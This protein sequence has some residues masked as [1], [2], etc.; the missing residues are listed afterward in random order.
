MPTIPAVCPQCESQYQVDAALVGKRMRCPNTICR[1]VFEVKDPNAKPA[2]PPAPPVI[3]PPVVAPAAPAPPPKQ[4]S[5][6]VA[7]LVPVLTAEAAETPPAPIP[8]PA[9]ATPAPIA[10]PPKRKKEKPETPAVRETAPAPVEAPVAPNWQAAPPP[11]R[12]QASTDGPP[13][14]TPGPQASA[15]A[16]AEQDLD[17]SELEGDAGEAVAEPGAAPT[18]VATETVV[19]PEEEPHHG[20]RRSLGLIVVMMLVLAGLGLGAFYLIKGKQAGNEAEHYDKAVEAYKKQDYAKAVTLLQGLTRDF[21][22]SGKRAEYRFLTE[23]SDLRLAVHKPSTDPAEVSR[24]LDRV[25]EFTELYKNDP[26][27]KDRHA[28]VWQSLEHVAKDLAVLAA[29]KNSGELLGR[30]KVAWKAAGK[31]TPPAGVSLPQEQK[32]FNE[33]YARIEKGIA[34][35]TYR[36]ES[37]ALLRKTAAGKGT[38]RAVEAAWRTIEDR[39]LQG[40]EEAKKLLGEL[41]AAHRENVAYN[42]VEKLRPLKGEMRERQTQDYA[43]API[44]S[45]SNTGPRVEKPFLALARGVLYALD[46]Y[47]GDIRWTRR[48]GADA[49]P[50]PLTVEASLAHPDF[51]VAV[52]SDP[53]ALVALEQA[54]GRELW[55]HP[56]AAP[57]LCD[58]IRVKDKLLVPLLSGRV[59]EVTLE[60][61]L[62][63]GF[64]ELGQR[65]SLGGVYDPDAEIVYLPADQFCLYALDVRN[66]RCEQTLYLRHEAGALQ[67]VPLVLEETPDGGKKAIRSLLVSEA[68]GE[69]ARLLRFTLPLESPDAAPAE[70]V[71]LPSPHSFPPRRDGAHLAVAGDD[72][73]LTLLGIRSQASGPLFYPLA[74]EGG[75]RAGGATG[76]PAMIAD[77][78]PNHWWIVRQGRLELF[79]LALADK[80]GLRVLPLWDPGL[81]IG[82]PLH[83]AQTHADSRTLFVVT[84]AADQPVVRATAVDATTGRIRWQRELGIVSQG[85]ILV[86]DKDLF[87]HGPMGVYRL[88]P[89]A[90][91]PGADAA[92]LAVDDGWRLLNAERLRPLAPEEETL[93]ITTEEGP[94]LVTWT[95]AAAPSVTLVRLGAKIDATTWKVSAPLL[96]TPAWHADHLVA[97]LADGRLIALAWNGNKG[98]ELTTWRGLGV[99][100]KQPGHVV[101]LGKTRLAFTDGNNKLTVLDWHDPGVAPAPR[102]TKAFDQRIVAVPVHVPE[103]EDFGVAVA[104]AGNRLTLL[105]GDTLASAGAWELPGRLSA[106]PALRAGKLACVVERSRLMILDPKTKEKVGHYVADAAII[107][108]PQVIDGAL[109]V[110]DAGGRIAWLEVKDGLPPRQSVLLRAQVSPVTAPAAWGDGVVI[111]AADGTLITVGGGK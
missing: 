29:D 36:Q 48:L 77:A 10:Q 75:I 95:K 78:D 11:V 31:F 85:P 54:S 107:D 68:K 74:P 106:G 15:V 45:A 4:Q 14:E 51:I 22:D 62:L 33:E 92:R 105:R 32:F 49:R 101:S 24:A 44:A 28:D 93:W 9:P 90:P 17:F 37:L 109:V 83:A 57:C 86:R 8:A 41:K 82:A 1:T 91:P 96:G 2:A 76:V 42:E 39:K 3:A 58:P 46:P 55:R 21:P 97:P 7:D 72:G 13:P 56:L 108:M 26:L 104:E 61:G 35:E 59:D 80:E 47:R 16:V 100:E 43:V 70:A 79:E 63:L 88:S 27:L 23:L 52:A 84:Q 98:T 20:R 19:A 69:G 38:A 89:P 18:A 64:W 40:E 25:L 73:S 99:D 87:V 60:S 34:A 103:K 111:G 66:H 67:S 12:G 30:S 6:N 94:A 71:T 65:L 50:L 5:G 53:P 102:G 110:A 81:L